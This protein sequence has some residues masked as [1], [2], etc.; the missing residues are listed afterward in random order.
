MF[1]RLK[2]ENCQL[3]WSMRAENK[4]ALDVSGAA[5]TGDE[6][7]HARIIAGVFLFQQI[8]RGG[9]VGHELFAPGE[10]DV[11]RRQHGQ[12]ASTRAA[13]GYQHAASLRNKR[14]TFADTDITRFEFV[15]IIALV[16]KANRQAKRS[17]N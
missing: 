3:L 7:N 16:R 4:D 8:K 15:N 2:T 13:I 12:R 5:G 17:G 6:G 14:V 1:Y 9:Q 10:H 11:V